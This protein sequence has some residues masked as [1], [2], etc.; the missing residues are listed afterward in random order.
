[1]AYADHSK[2]KVCY[3]YDR[4]SGHRVTF[5]NLIKFVSFQI[6]EIENSF[7]GEKHPMKPIRIAMAHDL[8]VNYGLYKVSY[9]Q[10]VF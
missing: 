4:K 10:S 7:Y 1:M 6:A 9:I 3:Y 8:I 2:K 5:A